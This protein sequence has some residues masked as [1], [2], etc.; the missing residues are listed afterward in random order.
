MKI[1]QS[2]AVSFVLVGLI[3]AGCNKEKFPSRDTSKLKPTPPPPPPPVDPTLVIFDAADKL[4]DW[5]VVGGGVEEKAGAREG[6]AYLKSTIHT[7]DDYMH[8]IKRRP[9][10]VDPKLSVEDGQFVFWFYVS[11]VTDLKLDGQIELTSSGKSDDH[12]YSWN[13][14]DYIPGL[15]VGWNE[16]KLN[17]S[18]AAKSGD[19]GPDIHA[20]NF[21]RIY[22]WTNDKSSHGDVTVGVDDLKFHARTK[23]SE[24]FNACDVIDNWETAGNVGTIDKSSKKEGVGSLKAPIADGGDFQQFIFRSPSVVNPGLTMDNGQLHFWFYVSDPTQLKVDGQIELTSSGKSDDHE[25]D[26]NLG[27]LIPNLKAGWNEM[28]LNFSDA[29]KTADGGADITALNYFKVYLWTSSKT[30]PEVVLAL[31]DLRL[32]EK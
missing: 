5:E 4:T 25:L 13:L 16:M 8:F 18:T 14:A 28:K 17:F 9:T 11:S 30:H 32:T 26:W 31:D 6:V 21:F 15:K 1:I 19:G 3:I 2:M 27:D 12:E 7:G 23:I 24:S 29:G 10:A 20:F 22:F